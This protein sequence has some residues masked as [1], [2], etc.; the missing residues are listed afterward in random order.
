M[1]FSLAENPARED[2]LVVEVVTGFMEEE[3]GMCQESASDSSRTHQILQF[4]QIF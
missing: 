1:W 2:K 4:L 3:L